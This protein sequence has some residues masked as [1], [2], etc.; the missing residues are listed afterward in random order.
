MTVVKRYGKPRIV[1]VRLGSSVVW[2]C[3]VAG[4][5]FAGYGDTPVKSFEAWRMTGAIRATKA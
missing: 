3:G 2:R 1:R 4:L 5:H